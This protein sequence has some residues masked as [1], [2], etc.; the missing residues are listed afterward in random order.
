MSWIREDGQ[1]QLQARI[2][3]G[4]ITIG[5]DTDVKQNESEQISAAYQ[6]FDHISKVAEEII[7]PATP[8]AVAN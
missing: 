3:G 2:G 7:Q 1:L 4:K 8:Q 6:L 5:A